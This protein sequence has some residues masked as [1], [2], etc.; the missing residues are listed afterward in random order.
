MSQYFPEPYEHSGGN[1][2]VELYLSNYATKTD[3]KGATGIDTSTLASKTDLA[4]LKTKVDDLDKDKIK[5]VPADLSKLCNV[6]DNDVVKKTG[7]GKL[8]IKVSAI[9]T[10]VPRGLVNK[11]QYDSDKQGLEKKIKNIDRKIVNTNGLG[12]KMTT[13]QKLQKLRTR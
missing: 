1:V 8:V 13:T 7:Y 12:K 11:T 6:M 2:K 9:D 4:S 3:L 10:K 5:T